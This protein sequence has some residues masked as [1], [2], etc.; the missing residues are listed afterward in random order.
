MTQ[1]THRTAP[2]RAAPHPCGTGN[3]GDARL[4]E[5]KQARIAQKTENL[6]RFEEGH[7]MIAANRSR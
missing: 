3:A 4:S 6:L 1:P 5:A 2:H 7:S